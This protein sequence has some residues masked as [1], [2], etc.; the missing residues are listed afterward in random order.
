MFIHANV[1]GKLFYFHLKAFILKQL[2]TTTACCFAKYLRLIKLTKVIIYKLS[3]LLFLSEQSF[4]L[5]RT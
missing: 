5:D 2:A 3:Q 4:L 1:P